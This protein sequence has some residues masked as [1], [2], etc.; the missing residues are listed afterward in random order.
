MVTQDKD[1]LLHAH[2]DKCG[3]TF[4]EPTMTQ[5]KMMRVLREGSWKTEIRDEFGEFP[6]IK[7]V[8]CEDCTAE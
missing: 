8:I 2:C 7:S 3:K 5:R 4:E 6:E 1:G